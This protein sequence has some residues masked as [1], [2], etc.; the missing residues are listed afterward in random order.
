VLAALGPRMLGLAAE[1]TWGA[2]TY[3]VPVEH[4]VR[5]RET[6]GKKAFLGVEQAVVLD[7]DRSRAREVA[8]SHV[9]GYVEMARHQRNNL[10]RLG[11]G[12][13]DLSNGGSDR[14]VDAI[15]AYGP[16]LRELAE[17]LP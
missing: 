4:T 11:F 10:S 9:A 16:A 3:F 5:A 14:M 17:V 7:A 15:V 2:H 12:E 1:R 8:R 6:L 13:A